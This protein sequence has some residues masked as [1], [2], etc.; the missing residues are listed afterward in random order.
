MRSHHIRVV[1][2][3]T[4]GRRLV[5]NVRTKELGYAERIRTDAVLVPLDRDT[6]AASSSVD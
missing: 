6:T 4:D 5:G 3:M 2:T 1:A